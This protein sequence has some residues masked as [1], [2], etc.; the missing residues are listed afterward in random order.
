GVELFGEAA[1]CELP[2][3]LERGQALVDAAEAREATGGVVRVKALAE[4][5]DARFA[6]GEGLFE[7]TAEKMHRRAYAH[8]GRGRLA[9]LART[10]ERRRA[11]AI[12]KLGAGVEKHGKIVEG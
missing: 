5:E 3:S 11:V 8:H 2:G 10:E 12:A 6:E 4:R 1:R 9:V 7:S